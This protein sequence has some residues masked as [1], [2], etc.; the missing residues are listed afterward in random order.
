MKLPLIPLDKAN[1]FI[2]GFVI[3]VLANLFLNQYY[4]LGITIAFGVSRDVMQK[5]TKKGNSEIM[6]AVWT[7]IPAI[8]LILAMLLSQQSKAQESIVVGGNS[9]ETFGEVFP[10][11]QTIAEEEEVTLSI[12]RFE[13][14]I[15]KPKQ[16]VKNKSIFEKILDFIR[17]LINKNK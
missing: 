5:I 4:S 12:P 13:M 14:P 3:Y 7:I 2:Y 17:K 11:M 1:H 16:D 9:I 15:E 8:I 10:I 6:D